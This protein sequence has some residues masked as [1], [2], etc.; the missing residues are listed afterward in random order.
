MT[1]VDHIGI[2]LSDKLVPKLRF[3]NKIFLESLFRLSGL[4]DQNKVFRQLLSKIE[5]LE[6]EKHK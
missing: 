4:V 5:I 6:R 3:G 2:N 1:R